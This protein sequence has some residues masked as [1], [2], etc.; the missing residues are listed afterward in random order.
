MYTFEVPISNLKIIITMT[1][2]WIKSKEY[3]DVI[4]NDML[5]FASNLIIN[6][7]IG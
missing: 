3:K 5:N 1:R 4:R 6:H 7:A 2:N